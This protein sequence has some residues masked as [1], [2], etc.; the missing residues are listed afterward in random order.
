MK[1]ELFVSY[2]PK[3]TKNQTEESLRNHR[4][5]T[6]EPRP[7]PSPPSPPP[8]ALPESYLH[9]GSLHNGDILFTV[10]NIFHFTRPRNQEQVDS[11]LAGILMATLP[12][13]RVELTPMELLM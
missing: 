10:G 13:I 7:G 5:T 8:P 2:L 6:E 3:E 12:S 9:L 1:L 4:G 11:R